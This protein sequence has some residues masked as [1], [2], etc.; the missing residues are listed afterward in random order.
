MTPT[1]PKKPAGDEPDR[2]KE[3][4]R[5]PRPGGHGSYKIG[6]E[7]ATGHTW[8]EAPPPPPAPS[9][10]YVAPA[11]AAPTRFDDGVPHRHHEPGEEDPLHNVDVEHEH[12]DV[13]LR[14]V[15]GSAIVLFVV[16]VVSQILMWALFVV[17]DKQAAANEPSVSPLAAPPAT[18]PNNQM[19]TAVFTPETV[20]GP[21]L[22]TNEPL[23]LLQQ[24]DKEQKVLHGY[25]WVNQAAGVARMP[26]D[27]A[28]KL[29]VERGLPVREGEEASPT[30]GTRLPAL[31]ESSG[32]RVIT[33]PA[34][35]TTGEAAPAAP[36]G[37]HGQPTGQQPAAPAHG[38]PAKPQGRGGH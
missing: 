9:G 5:G 29:I 1:D 12:A 6:G 28:K 20:A 15:I 11:A 14:A 26:I 30:L 8:H 35:E 16:V 2:T 4:R 19:G 17:F 27:E 21:H 34:Q 25:G 23:N 10:R 36:A 33:V 7:P 13:D 3:G 38:E 37:G 18:M 32:G 24:R 22:L 31:G